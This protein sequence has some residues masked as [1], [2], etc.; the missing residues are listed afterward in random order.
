MDTGVLEEAV[1]ALQRT[2]GVFGV[3]EGSA[4]FRVCDT[5]KRCESS[6]FDPQMKGYTPSFFTT[7]AAALEEDLIVNPIPVWIKQRP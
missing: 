6:K 3:S 1:D 5:E 2:C 4:G 7:L